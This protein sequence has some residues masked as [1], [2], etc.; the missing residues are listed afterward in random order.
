MDCKRLR[1]GVAGL[2][3]IGWNFHCKSLAKH[4]DFELAAVADTDPVRCREAEESM[5]CRPFADYNDMVAQGCLDAVVIATPT[6]LHESMVMTALDANLHILLEKPM[7]PT[8][9]E[10][11]RIV[12]AAEQAGRVLTIY[13]PHRHHAYF[14]HLLAILATGKIGKIYWVQRGAFSYSRRN[15]WQSLQKF[16]GGM[17]NNYGAHYLD[18][19]LQLVGYDIKRVF[20]NLQIVASLGDADDV[21]K[22]VFETEH[23][24]L[25]ECTINQAS[26]SN[27]YEF[28]VWGEHGTVTYSRSAY[29]ISWFDPDSLPEK[30]LDVSLASADRKYPHDKLELSSETIKVDPAYQVDVFADFAAA[31]REGSP[32]AVPPRETLALMDL[33]RRC[34]EGSAGI[35][36]MKG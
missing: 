13:Q 18:Q 26:V 4:P 19:V 20:C 30:V 28:I 32:V 9:D 8:F 3:R 6:H 12:V 22:V 29:E 10:A 16:G 24:A 35:R 2:G 7:A 25:G 21:V 27:P 34:R 14:Q 5:G 17:L 15:D 23:G 11:K 1:I 31:I 36:V 33:L